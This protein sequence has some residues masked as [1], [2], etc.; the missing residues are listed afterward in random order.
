MSQ[1]NSQKAYRATRLLAVAAIP[2]LCWGVFALIFVFIEFAKYG[3]VNEEGILIFL[4]FTGLPAGLVVGTNWMLFGQAT[5]WSR[6]P[7]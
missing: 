5:F 1:Q 7:D 2:F 4:A 6:K 3:R